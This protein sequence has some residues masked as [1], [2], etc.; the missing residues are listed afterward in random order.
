[1]T[2]GGA[3]EQHLAGGNIALFIGKI[4]TKTR[5]LID[6]LG[7]LLWRRAVEPY[8]CVAADGGELM[9]RRS[10]CRIGVAR[11]WLDMTGFDRMCA[12]VLVRVEIGVVAG[13]EDS[14][15]MD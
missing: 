6:R 10:L 13:R 12:P 2:A 14:D 5:Q 3:I 8:T 4:P 1:M 15:E 7:S 11:L 9:E